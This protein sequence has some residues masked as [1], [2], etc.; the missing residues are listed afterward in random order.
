MRQLSTVLSSTLAGLFLAPIFA[1]LLSGCAS[2]STATAPIPA[3]SRATP[4]ITIL[5]DAF[6]KNASMK[7]DWGFAALVEVNG[8]RILFDLVRSAP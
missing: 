2:T 1:L 4:R 3:T 8:L 6:G 7:K 5:Y